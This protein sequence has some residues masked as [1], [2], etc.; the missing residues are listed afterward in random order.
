L[1]V[2]HDAELWVGIKGVIG[3]LLEVD[4]VRGLNRTTTGTQ[5]A[6]DRKS[7]VTAPTVFERSE[8]RLIK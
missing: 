4:V 1:V 5:E 2:K 6:R 7:L 8:D 3:G